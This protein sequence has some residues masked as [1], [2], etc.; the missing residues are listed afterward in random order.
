[1]L[2]VARLQAGRPLDLDRGPMDLVDLARR[3]TT[4]LRPGSERHQ[5]EVAS[6][7]ADLV[8]DWDRFRLERV[9]VNLV[10]NAIKYSPEGGPVRVEVAREQRNG[11]EWAVLR[12]CDRG[13]GIPSGDLPRVFDRFYRGSN[14]EGRIEGTGIGLSGARQIVEQHGGRVSVESEE[15]VGSPFTVRLP[16]GGAAEGG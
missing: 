11:A 12:V 6:E 8:G 2:D 5:I 16:L 15:Q 10:S 1:M 3:V 14:V 9:L 7:A 13:V 4:E